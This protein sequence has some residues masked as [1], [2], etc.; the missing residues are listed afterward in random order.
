MSNDNEK[1]FIKNMLQGVEHPV[2]VDL[3][4]YHGEDAEWMLYAVAEKNPR[5]LMVEADRTNY[6]IL[7]DRVY[8]G[9]VTL[10]H[11][12]VSDH[13]G[14]CDFWACY[15]VEGSGSGSIREPTG[16]REKDGIQYD[17]RKTDEQIPCYSLDDL[18]ER[19]RLRHIDI[20]W[21]DLQGAERDMIA[22]GQQALKHTAFL[23]IEAE[24][25]ELYA[26]QALRQ[27]LLAMLPNWTVL[28]VFEQN[29]LLRND[30]VTN[31]EYWEPQP[32]YIARTTG[33]FCPL[34]DSQ[35]IGM[36]SGMKRCNQCGHAFL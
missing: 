12:A 18:F 30:L 10:L 32:S 22:G 17:F 25:C 5:G 4:A 21:V 35:A 28:H 31:L 15:T 8:P 23:W 6:Q 36:A 29:I 13:T 7:T 26:G 19:E 11:A 24:E 3:G 9:H 2:I 14:F 16:H 34:C 33:S 27:E 1:F 20:L